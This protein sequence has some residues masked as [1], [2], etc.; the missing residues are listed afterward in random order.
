MI[1]H[2]MSAQV[3]AIEQVVQA[4]KRGEISQAAIQASVNRINKL[5]RKYLPPLSYTSALPTSVDMGATNKRHAALASRMYAKSTTVIRSVEGHLP[6][7][8]GPGTKSV[9]LFPGKAPLGGGLGGG[10]V[11]S[12]E[13]K[14]REPY[15]KNSFIDLVKPDNLLVHAIQYFDSKSLDPAEEALIEQADVVVFCTRNASLSQ[16]QKDLGISLGKKLGSKFI[17][18]ATCDPYD[19]L[20]DVKAVQNYIATYEPTPEAFQSALNV[21]FGAI[22]ASGVLPVGSARDK[23]KVRLLDNASEDE[24]SHVWSLFQN[25]F[26]AWQIERDHLAD[27]LTKVPGVHLIH[28]KGFSLGYYQKTSAGDLEGMLSVVGVVESYRGKGLGTALV[29]RTREELKAQSE[30]GKLVSFGISSSFPRFWP[31]I[32]LSFPSEDRDFFIHRGARIPLFCDSN[33][34]VSCFNTHEPL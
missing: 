16:Y 6:V 22:P 31:G 30:T 7:S 26:P 23:P 11:D 4:V 18:V 10:A 5:K 24:I 20:E 28:D 15:L 3:G 17:A 14:T 8:K 1:C 19:F 2:T 9:Y 25:I 12:G 21:I 33:I 27:L 34:A 13:E 29:N 32:P